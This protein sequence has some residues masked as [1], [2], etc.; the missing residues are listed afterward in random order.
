[1]QVVSVPTSVN[2]ADLFTKSLTEQRILEL[3]ALINLE[4]RAGRADTAKQLIE[5]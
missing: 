2:I 1:M 3:L 4:F 5:R